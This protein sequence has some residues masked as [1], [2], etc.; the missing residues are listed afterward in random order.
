MEQSLIV[1]MAE[2]KVLR[3]NHAQNPGPADRFA[4]LTALGLGSCIGI[5]LY[6]RTAQVAG[7]A[8]IVLPESSA[9]K[10]EPPGKFADTAL[11]VLIEEMLQFGASRWRLVAAISGG[12]Q[13]FTIASDPTRLGVGARNAAAV[14]DGL[15]RQGIPVLARDLGGSQGRTV[16]LYAVDGRVSVKTIGQSE[17][18]LI[19]LGD[20]RQAE[21][22][23][24][25]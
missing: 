23:G 8:H 24:M 9:R 12:A 1:G 19:V 10:D 16:R 14:T 20:V 3:V 6:D 21:M 18:E 2:I 13:L 25:R 11:P 17:R 4:V 15:G 22:S 7:M 5:C